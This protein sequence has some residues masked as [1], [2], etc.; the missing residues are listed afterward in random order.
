MS[1]L[2]RTV[3]ETE[4]DEEAVYVVADENGVERELVPVYS[5][6][7]ADREYVVLIDRNDPETDGLI[8]R[9]E[10][11]GEEVVLANIEDDE[12]WN[13]VVEI[14]NEIVEQEEQT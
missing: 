2:D 6:D 12:E 3:N 10:Q 13:A 9:I 11:E 14:Y 5:F 7:Y 4:E 1:D 8:L